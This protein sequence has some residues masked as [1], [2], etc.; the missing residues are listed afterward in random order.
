MLTD[1]RFFPISTLAIPVP[2]HLLRDQP[3]GAPRPRAALRSALASWSVVSAL[4]LL[5]IGQAR[6]SDLSVPHGFSAGTPALAAE[7]NANFSAV[8]TAVDDNDARIIQLEAL[9]ATLQ[10]QLAA[11]EASN[12]MAIDP[13]IEL[14]DIANPNI[15]VL[16]TTVR[17]TG[18]NLQVV[19]GSGDTQG[20]ETGLGNLIVGYNELDTH[21]V[22]H[23]RC[24]NGSYDNGPDCVSNGGF[25]AT[26]HRSGSHNL[27]VGRAN[28]YSSHG[29]L[30]AGFRHLSSKQYGSVAGGQ[31]NT[32]SGN[33]SAIAGGSGN[34]ASGS[35]SAVSGGGSNLASGS[36]VVVGGGSGNTA[37]G[38]A[39]VVSGGSENIASGQYASISGG[40]ENIAS[41]NYASV[42]GGVNSES[43]GLYASVSG[44]SSNIAD[45]N[46]ASVSGGDGNSADGLH[47][48]ISG[49]LGNIASGE[50]ATVSGGNGNVA[51]GFY[52]TVSGGRTNG[53][54]GAYATVS[55]GWNRVSGG[56]Y[57]W[58]AG[59]LFE[60]D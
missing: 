24:S 40:S 23:E 59:D 19:D 38:L 58:R 27:V 8:E 52:A 21:P 13:Y 6:A 34:T 26:D 2:Y 55:G 46:S 60:E 56:T 37:S 44:G 20:T 54:S 10:S 12:V 15:G 41:G 53:A 18:A 42:S 49:G 57:D 48:S 22:P 5:G 29:G 28:S 35:N 17:I 4:S 43:G 51:A 32:A 30:L 3:G 47:A 11:I 16:Y 36:F 50:S 7:V 1:R 25:W 33:W 45:G 9:V 31:N 39:S 14:T